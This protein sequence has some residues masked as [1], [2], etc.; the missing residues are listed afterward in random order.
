MA[1]QFAPSSSVNSQPFNAPQSAQMG[2]TVDANPLSALGAITN[3]NATQQS[4]AASRLATQRAR[5]TYEADVAKAK[6]SSERE[7]VQLGVDQLGFQR[8]QLESAAQQQQRL[9]SKSDL[10]ADDIINATVEH[11]KQ[12]K[13]Q[14][15]VV[16]QALQGLPKN[17]TP[18]DYQAYLASNLANTLSAQS[19]FDKLYPESNMTNVGGA[20]VPTA[21]GNQLVTGVAPGAQTGPAIAT[22][23]AP[24]VFANPITGQPTIIGAGRQPGSQPQMG[25][26][27][28]VP[29]SSMGTG[30]ANV[31]PQTG[32]K[33]GAQT[34]AQPQ[35]NQQALKAKP[36]SDQLTQGANESPANFNARVAQTQNAV[37]KA[38][39]QFN[40]PSSEFGHI[41][42]VKTINTNILGLLKDPSVNTGSVQSFIAGKIRQENLSAKEQELAKYL[43]QRVQ[44]LSPKSDA[45]ADAKRKAYGTLELKKEA[46]MDLIRQDNAWIATQELQA[47]G[48]LNAG[49]DPANPNF[50]RVAQFNNQFAKLAQ[51]P[52]LMKYIG[53]VGEG[54]G[55]VA[56][57]SDDIKALQKELGSMSP[58]KRKALEL[59]RQT[60]LKLVNGGQ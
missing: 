12:F 24:Q 30:G 55:K 5:D 27:N 21:R 11:A 53:I 60:L 35:T 10:N 20:I 43:A 14:P 57:D 50:G 6:A 36:V 28:A 29:L 13:L 19:Q 49:G 15:E 47:K 25:G 8:K 41:P 23:I 39:D 4:T 37:A 52:A 1:F 22:T 40:N 17:G 16:Q 44:N 26:G 54:Q 2:A 58:E 45:D 46:L 59:Q 51:N 56:L 42:T 34:G 18:K 33:T 38:Q 32:A 48:V 7:Q 9:M 31:Q 3:I